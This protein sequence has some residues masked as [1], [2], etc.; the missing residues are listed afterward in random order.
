MTGP[1]LHITLAVSIA[2]AIIIELKTFICICSVLSHENIKMSYGIV[3]VYIFVD[4]ALFIVLYRDFA[5]HCTL[6]PLT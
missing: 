1:T 6:F 3:F 2:I 5:M 4:L